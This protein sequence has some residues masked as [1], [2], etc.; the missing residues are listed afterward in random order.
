MPST[1]SVQKKWIQDLLTFFWFP[2][3]KW[4]QQVKAT[5]MLEVHYSSVHNLSKL[6]SS[7]IVFTET[8]KKKKNA[9]NPSKTL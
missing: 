6:C 8:E 4:I 5:F 9:K 7:G 1:A 3:D 2:E